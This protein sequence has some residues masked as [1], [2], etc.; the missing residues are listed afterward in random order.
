[1]PLIK[2]A[3]SNLSQGVSQQADSQR[4]PSQAEEQ[5]NAYSSHIKGLVKR[6]PTKH[7]STVGI[8]GVTTDNV[9]DC[10]KTFIH[11]I[12][13]SVGERYIVVVNKTD[14]IDVSSFSV[15]NNTLT[16]A[17]SLTAGDGIRLS[18]DFTEG[19]LPTGL[20][21]NVTYYVKTT[22]T[23]FSLSTKTDLSDTVYFGKAMISKLQLE[24][25]RH[26]DKRWIAVSYTHLTLPTNRE[27]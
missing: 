21:P 5:I 20:S 23:T 6:P 8:T 25:V 22:G 3:A 17:T 4:F 16:T 7:V 1:M 14:T 18:S 19:V 11:T 24:S 13:R 15:S 2:N 9:P 27:V 12:N 10:T 26:T